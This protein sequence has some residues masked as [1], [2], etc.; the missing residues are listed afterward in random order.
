[1]TRRGVTPYLQSPF[2]SSLTMYRRF[3]NQIEWENISELEQL[4]SVWDQ[5]SYHYQGEVERGVRFLKAVFESNGPTGLEPYVSDVL[6]V[7]DTLSAGVLVMNTAT[8][9][10]EFING[11]VA[12]GDDG[13]S[14]SIRTELVIDLWNLR[15][16]HL[17]EPLILAKRNLVSPVGSAYQIN[18]GT[19]LG[20]SQRL[21]MVREKRETGLA[22]LFEFEWVRFG[23]GNAYSPGEEYAISMGDHLERPRVFLNESIENFHGL[24][25][26]PNQTA[27]RPS[28]RLKTRRILDTQLAV[29]IL[30][31]CGAHLVGRVWALSNGNGADRNDDVAYEELSEIE[32]QVLTAYSNYFAPRGTS[33][34]LQD[35][36]MQIAALS[37]SAIREFVTSTMP[38]RIRRLLNSEGALQAILDFGL[39]VD[40]AEV[41]P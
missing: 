11:R 13:A 24:M 14:L 16:E 27:G 28:N 34:D 18:Q 8:R 32:A 30:Q 10:R 36:C 22:D 12:I 5:W 37:D 6:L 19:I 38:R 20:S 4:E 40:N 23:E 17:V 1:M 7:D 2:A 33:N 9:T 31:T 25:D 21:R 15:G 26:T 39:S 41:R 3:E 29:G 35:L